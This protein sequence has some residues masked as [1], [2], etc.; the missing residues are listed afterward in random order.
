[1]IIAAG[2]I[3][4]GAMSRMKR[5]NLPNFTI[6]D[7]W[8]F[9]NLPLADQLFAWDLWRFKTSVLVNYD[10]CRKLVSS[11]ELA[12]TFDERFKAT[13]VPFFIPNFNLLSYQL[14]NFTFKVL[15]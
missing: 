8:I 9:D 14:D 10:L 11:L 15:Y 1:M 4:S 5:R 7:S 13:L 12:I 2:V 6:L 3:L